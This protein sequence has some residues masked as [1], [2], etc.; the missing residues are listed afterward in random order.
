M[1]VLHQDVWFWKD[2]TLVLGLVPIG[3]AYHVLFSC[4]CACLMLFLV[5][6][7]WPKHLDEADAPAPNEPG[8]KG[9]S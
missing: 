4:T 9:A 8:S 5:K 6:T 1:V 2:R 3:L 7:L